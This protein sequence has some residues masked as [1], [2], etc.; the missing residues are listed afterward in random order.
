MIEPTYN[1]EVTSHLLGA[2]A[3]GDL[4][5]VVAAVLESQVGDGEARDAVSPAGVCWQWPTVL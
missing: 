4:A 2:K 1:I 3:I 5:D